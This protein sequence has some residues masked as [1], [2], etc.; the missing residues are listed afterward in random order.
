VHRPHQLQT[1]ALS[2][3]FFSAVVFHTQ[4]RTPDRTGYRGSCNRSTNTPFPRARK[5]DQKKKTNTKRTPKRTYLTNASTDLPLPLNLEAQRTKK[6]SLN[7]QLETAQAFI[8]Q[9]AFPEQ[10]KPKTRQKKVTLFCFNLFLIMS[11][12]SKD[13]SSNLWAPSGRCKVASNR[14]LK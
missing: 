9:A 13:P 5:P 12:H 14:K 3:L 6:A 8:V 4:H 11:R 1:T 2:T 10:I 7:T